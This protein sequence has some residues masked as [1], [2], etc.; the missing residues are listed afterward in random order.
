MNTFRIDDRPIG[1]RYPAYVIGEIGINHNGE[2]A[3][4][5]AL[6][7]VGSRRRVATPSSS[8]SA[9][10]RSAFHSTSSR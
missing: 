5:K 2:L 4:A 9:R 6:I 8:R 7:D 10:P 1:V 3:I